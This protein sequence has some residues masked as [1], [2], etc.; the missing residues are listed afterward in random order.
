MRVPFFLGHPV[1]IT[2]LAA[3]Y[4]F[5]GTVAYEMASELKRNNETVAMVFMVDTYAWFPKALT[6]CSEYIKK[7]TLKNMESA[8]KF[9]VSLQIETSFVKISFC[10]FHFYS[11]K[12]DFKT[13]F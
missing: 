7:C 11:F 12:H 10:Y 9:V 6:S 3:G 1:Y 5:G 2:F 8:E 13:A 4:S